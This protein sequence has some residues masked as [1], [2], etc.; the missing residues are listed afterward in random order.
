[1]KRFFISI[2]ISLFILPSSVAYSVVEPDKTPNIINVNFK[3]A[4]LMEESTGKILYEHNSHNKLSPASVTKVMTLLLTMEDLDNGKI[5][6]SDKVTISARA[7][8]IG[9]TT[10][11]L[12]T[13]EVRSVEDLI[14]GIVMQSA[15]DG[16]VA[17][18]EFLGGSEEGFVKRMNDR[19]S[20]LGMKDT[21]FVNPMG[22]YS[23]EH[24]TSA[25]DIAIMSRELLKHKQILNY[26]KKW[27][28]TISEGRKAPI[29]LVNTNK[30]VRAYSGCDGLKTGYVPESK[31]CISATAMRNNIRFIA[32]I[33]AAPTSKDRNEAAGKLLNYGF[34][35][36]ESKPVIKRNEQVGELKFNRAK[37]SLTKVL[38]KQDLNLIVPKGS[39]LKTEFKLELAPNLKLP[40]KEGEAIGKYIVFDNTGVLGEVPVTVENNLSKLE[41]GDYI[42][43][44]FKAWINIK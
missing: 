13:G 9:G 32:V 40:I 44:T 35:S 38:T 22:F 20:E 3:S 29:D 6:L 11:C 18:S 8:S 21:H 27:M 14:K 10:M 31:Y 5:K 24:Y 15:N 28:E 30:M 17:M 34:A 41:F 26:S 42:K 4:L 16:A 39:K 25:Y 12:Q 37:P 33:M 7:H 2:L 36:Y 19:A 23:P 43:K 1:M